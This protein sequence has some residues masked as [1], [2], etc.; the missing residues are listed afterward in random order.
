MLD[1]FSW[2]IPNVIAGSS[3]PYEE[4][5]FTYLK[6]MG[7]KVIINLTSK[8]T[9]PIYANDFKLYHLRIPDF[10]VPESKMVKQFFDIIDEAEKRDEP[11]LVHCFAGCGRTG[12][13]LALWAIKNNKV[14]KNEDAIPYIRNK[15]DCSVE[16]D[17]QEEFVKEFNPKQI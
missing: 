6:E 13:M 11:V 4:S 9:D 17:L 14:I 1:N 15:R 5:H 12:T 7:I 3:L 10:S 2:V 8:P 16:T